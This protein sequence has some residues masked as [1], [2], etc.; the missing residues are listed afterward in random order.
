VRALECR[1]L[2]F[3]IITPLNSRHKEAQKAQ[4]LFLTVFVLFVPFCG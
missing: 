4:A 3:G 1:R 2:G